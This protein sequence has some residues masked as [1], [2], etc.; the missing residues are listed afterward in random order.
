MKKKMI[1]GRKR[2]DVIP[3]IADLTHEPHEPTVAMVKLTPAK[4]KPPTKI[5]IQVKRVHPSG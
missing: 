4:P 2:K 3:V 1:Y 5:E